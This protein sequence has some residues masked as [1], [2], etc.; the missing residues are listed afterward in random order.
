MKFLIFGGNGFL[1]NFLYEHLKKKY[2]VYRVSRKQK[3]G[4]YA[5]ELNQKS[6]SKILLKIKPNIIINTI[7]LTDVDLCELNKKK[8]LNSNYTILKNITDVIKKDSKNFNNTFL[9]HIS[10]DQV[11]SGKGPHSEKRVKPKN[12]YAYTKLKAEKLLINIKG[13]VLRTNFLGKSKNHKN[14]NNWIAENVKNKKKIFGYRNIFFSPLSMDTLGKNIVRI[15]KKKIQG[16]YN[17]GSVGGISKGDYIKKFLTKNYPKFDDFELIN[18]N[19]AKRPK[20]AIRP[21][22]MRLNS[23]KFATKYKIKLPNTN[24]EVKKIIKKFKND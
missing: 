17:L 19:L 6:I 9:I 21:N 7:A 14:F 13:C 12:Y 22:D 3:I 10:T 15:S 2:S 8:A 24:F 16:T 4:L 5:D 11:Y 18:Y 20:S 23:K 1:G